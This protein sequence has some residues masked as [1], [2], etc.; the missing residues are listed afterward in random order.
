MLAIHDS[1]ISLTG[2]YKW[3]QFKNDTT[4]GVCPVLDIDSS[5]CLWDHA[6]V[7]SHNLSNFVFR[8]RLLL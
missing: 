3:F 7:M 6:F 4:S 2:F 8:T 1:V 5:F